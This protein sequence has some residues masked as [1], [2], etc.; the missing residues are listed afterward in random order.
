MLRL[1]GALALVVAGCE[2]PPAQLEGRIH[3]TVI[4]ARDESPVDGASVTADPGGTGATADED[5]AF[6]LDLPAGRYSLVASKPGRRSSEPVE[7]VI[8][9]GDTADVV[10][11]I[12]DLPDELTVRMP[13]GV[14]PAG[15]DELVTLEAEAVDPEGDS[16]TYTWRQLRGPDITPSFEGQGTPALTLRTLSIEEV[17][18]PEG[19]F[20]P[21]PI[22]AFGQGEYGIELEVSDG[23]HTAT[24]QAAIRSGSP[25][26][27]WPRLAFGIDAYFDC[28]GIATPRFRIESA[29]PCIPEDPDGGP[30]TDCTPVE[31]FDAD[32]CTPRLRGHYY[33]SFE[34]VEQTSGRQVH[35]LVGRWFGVNDA[36]SSC[37]RPECH[38][39]A[40]EKWERTR[41]AS[42]FTRAIDGELG[43]D[44]GPACARCHTLGN[45]AAGRNAGFDDVSFESGWRW[46][47]RFEPGNWD[48]V[49]DEVKD[50]A[51]VQCSNCHAPGMFWKGYGV[52]VCAQC[53]DAPPTYTKVAEWRASPMSRFVRSLAEDDPAL[54][55]GCT[56][57]HSAQGAVAAWR[58]EHGSATARPDALIDRTIPNLDETIDAPSVDEVQPITCVACHD[59][60]SDLPRMLRV[61]GVEHIP[62]MGTTPID[63]GASAVCLRCH[64]S[65]VDPTDPETMARRLAPMQGAQS[66]V[67]YGSGATEAR[68]ELPQH[69][70]VA[71]CTD[72]HMKAPAAGLEGA[73]GGHTFLVRAR[74]GRANLAACS[75]CHEEVDDFDVEALGDWDGDGSVESGRAE[76]RGLVAVVQEALA[77]A[78]DTAAIID[79]TGGARAVWFSEVDARIV[80]V[81]GA[82]E[83]L[84]DC[85]GWPLVFADDQ[86]ALHRV[87]FDLLLLER[88]GSE[89]L[90]A[91]RFAARVLQL[92][93]TELLGDAVPEW[94]LAERSGP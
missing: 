85:D 33:G 93:A 82:G 38:L 94:D 78:I 9:R 73:A 29:T 90:H 63:A 76:Y 47:E 54:R 56:R 23:E 26:G 87:A 10:L 35:Y 74:G 48:A 41:H 7:L 91:P 69:A 80:L 71:V 27:G 17:V 22:S 42:V 86:L 81:D 57:C 62:S 79:C 72:C 44:Y 70:S 66:D 19:R 25:S 5:G 39:I 24:A 51:N 52:G 67:F 34:L 21:M 45:D 14:V 3:G 13:I 59:V 32:T 75:G 12:P 88:D 89:G 77:G 8:A 65:Q 84:V 31:L 68:D 61:R 15:Y 55:K 58:A 1:I 18:R 53:H 46:P 6:V 11:T 43:P 49:P 37:V 92:A 60:K 83:P 40:G 20:G 30:P 4:D 2:Q 64:N 16:L 50:L 28:G 36:N